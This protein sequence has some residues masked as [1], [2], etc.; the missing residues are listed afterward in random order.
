MNQS[1]LSSCRLCP[2]RCGADRTRE[3][4][5]CGGG[6]LPRV[7]RAALHFWEEPCLSGTRGSGA[8]FFSGCSLRCVYCQNYRISTGNFGQEVSI[9]RLAQIIRELEEQGAHNINLVSAA[10]YVPQIL[11]AFSLY[12]PSIPVVYNSSGY[13]SLETL[14]LLEGVVDIYLPDLKY[15]DPALSARYSAAPDY[16]ER[17]SQALLEMHRQVGESVLN[18]EGIMTRGMIVRHLVIPGQEENTAQVLEWLA[19][20]LPLTTYL[21]LMCQYTPA[22]LADQFPEINR[23]LERREYRRAQA[24]MRKLGFQNGFT[25]DPGSSGSQYIPPFNLEGVASKGGP[26]A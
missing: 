24:R 11:E 14:R 25:Q 7:A 23:P 20:H 16:F 10:H 18:R 5:R 15:V 12:R 2:R 9:P 13:E 17:A 19:G 3:T 26:H 21:S 8:I 1:I 6:L 22:G 4:G